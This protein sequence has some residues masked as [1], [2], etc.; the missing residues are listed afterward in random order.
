M[1]LFEDDDSENNDLSKIQIDH[2]FAKRYEYNKKRED[3]QR[4]EELKKNGK[5]GVSRSD[6][7]DSSS[8]D[9][10][11]SLEPSKKKDFEFF[12]ALIKVKNQ[13]PVLKDK[14][15]KLFYSDSE[16]ESDS[17]NERTKRGAGD[18][19]KVKK[20]IFLKDVVS[21]QLIEAGPEFDDED[22]GQINKVKT[23][24]EEQEEFTRDI[25]KAIE[26]GN[27]HEDE[28]GDF[29][30]VK[31]GGGVDGTEEENEIGNKL[32]EYFG[33]DEKLDTD[34]MFLKDYF[35][36]R[37][38]LDDGRSNDAGGGDIEFSEDEEEI[39]RQEDYEREFNFRF[40]EN[41]GDR[42]MGHSRRVEGSVRKKE[43]SRKLQRDRKEERSAQAEFERKE[44]LKYLK[45]LKKKEIN[46]KLQKIREVA[47]IGKSEKS[48]LDEDYLEE[49]FDPEEYDM[50]MGEAFDEEYYKAE[51]VDPEFGS[52][53]DGDGGTF[54]KPDFDKEDEL[55]GLPKNWDDVKESGE[56]FAS[57]R[58]RILE[59]TEGDGDK[60]ELLEEGHNES[61]RSKKRKPSEIE[62]AVREQLMEEYYKLDYED[63]VGDIKTRFKYKP[64]KP[65]R[66]G[67][68]PYQILKMDEKDLN[69]Y[70]S[71]KKLAPYTEKEWKV[72]RIKT[73]QL[74]Q[75]NGNRLHGETS[76]FVNKDK[77]KLWH[78]DQETTKVVGSMEDDKTQPDELNGDV[79]N[80]SRRS[81]RRQRQAELKLSRSRLLAYGKVQPKSKS[82]KH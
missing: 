57:A 82:K 4:Y 35:R 67:L 62:K 49:E 50:K 72:P 8:P 26:E 10:E 58:R 56:G 70:V 32:D 53:S 54:Q 71:L 44:E 16:N 41:A 66:Y 81:K 2:K 36:K 69:Q 1:K 79:N 15:A 61:K 14:D 12:D 68:S 73:M 23:Y 80:I 48:L 75:M 29:F 19:E 78:G 13:D 37:M 59:R 28:D 55:L 3:L 18:G 74:K 65:R 6:S 27:N 31:E 20:P 22:D 33:E 17:G 5:L 40:E 77:K 21:R 47:G 46:E 51:D 9:E 38:W 39:E 63:T 25:L 43:N 42:V 45:N 34:A 7:E 60:N 11:L 52:G 24:S 64:V 76:A 30:R